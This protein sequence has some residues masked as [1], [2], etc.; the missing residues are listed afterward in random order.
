M[1]NLKSLRLTFLGDCWRLPF[2]GIPA[3]LSQQEAEA[4]VP[5]E[6]L[7]LVS[8]VGSTKLGFFINYQIAFL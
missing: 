7:S 2:A 1:T 6:S 4:Q 8:S 3:H 5:T